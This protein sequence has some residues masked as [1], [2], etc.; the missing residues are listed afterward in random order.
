MPN[1]RRRR[2]ET[3]IAALLAATAV[4]LSA[5]RGDEET[6]GPKQ[7][8]L[9]KIGK[10]DEPTYLTQPP[11]ED[12]L[13]FVVERPG[14]I[15]V[16][17]HDKVVPE[18]FLDIRKRVTATGDEQGMLSMAFDPGYQTNGLF[19]VAYT[20]LSGDVRVDEFHSTKSKLVAD[21]DTARHVVRIRENSS[22]HHGGLL[23]FGPDNHLYVGSG[24]GG[25]SFD[26]FRTAQRRDSLLGK[27][28][29]IDPHKSGTGKKKRPYTIPKD[30]PFVGKHGADEVFAYGLRNPWRFSFDRAT[31]L[32]AIGDVGQDRFEEI[33][34]LPASRARGANFG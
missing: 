19:Y 9:L 32:M 31:G 7:L 10:F 21:S 5:E 13:L 26:P 4:F 16:V 29:R 6:L 25:P 15:R 3:V 20:A 28:L 8:T 2:I 14:V 23:V 22:K 18:P 30:N 12:N 33:D 11:R 17:D 24:D 1:R 27:I 34:L